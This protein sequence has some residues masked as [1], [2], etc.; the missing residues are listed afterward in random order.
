MKQSPFSRLLPLLAAFLILYAC[1]AVSKDDDNNDSKIGA[2]A[3][4][5]KDAVR[6]SIEAANDVFEKAMMSGD[7]TTVAKNYTSDA[8]V[9]GANMPAI[10]GSD[11]IVGFAGEFAR[12][13]V[14]DFK[15][16]TV[17][18]WGSDELVVEEGTYDMKDEK[19]NNL[20]KGKYIV[21]WKKEDGKWKMFRDIFNSDNP[22]PG[23][24]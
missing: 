11:G 22:V 10:S 23:S 5:N 3:V 4:F 1:D 12:M 13:G 24:H 15:L 9:M 17:D 19:G 21:V 16:N 8:K 6:D 20:D 2:N 14:K 18:I 7:S